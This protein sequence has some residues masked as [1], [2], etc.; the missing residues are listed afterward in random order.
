MHSPDSPMRGVAREWA[1][2]ET[3]RHT[4][5]RS[6]NISREMGERGRRTGERIYSVLLFIFLFRQSTMGRA[7]APPPPN[8]TSV[9]VCL[10]GHTR[11]APLSLGLSWIFATGDDGKCKQSSASPLTTSHNTTFQSVTE[12]SNFFPLLFQLSEVMGWT[13]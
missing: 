8:L 7:P 12:L 4:R 6:G 10:I 3:C 13:W 9:G 11:N 2:P 1:G 5:E